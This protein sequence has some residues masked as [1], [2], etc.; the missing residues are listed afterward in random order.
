ME[1]SGISEMST[2]VLN[3][4]VIFSQPRVMNAA[5]SRGGCDRNGRVWTFLPRA[6]VTQLQPVVTVRNVDPLAK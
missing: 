1:A 3:F 5:G 2:S 4:A 6:A